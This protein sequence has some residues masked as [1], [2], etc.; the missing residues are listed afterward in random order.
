MGREGLKIAMPMLQL[1][2]ED[3]LGYNPCEFHHNWMWGCKV[4]ARNMQYISLPASRF[5]GLLSAD[6]N[7]EEKAP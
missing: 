1:E 3:P 7:L 5:G 4:K 6:L 2:M